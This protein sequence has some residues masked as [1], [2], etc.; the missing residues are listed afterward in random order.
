MDRPRRYT[1]IF[2]LSPVFPPETRPDYLPIFVTGAQAA[3]VVVDL[4]TGQA[5]VKRLAAAQD[6]GRAINPTGA[7][8]QIQ[9]A[10]LM[11]CRFRPRWRSSSRALSTGFA[12]YILPM[13][14]ATSGNG[15]HPG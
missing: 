1:G 3:Q 11:G 8:G 6:V 5:Q 9:G 4:E 12:N 15:S 2:D 14:G 10:A 7:I 13:V